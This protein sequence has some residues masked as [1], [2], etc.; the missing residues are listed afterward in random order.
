MRGERHWGFWRAVTWLLATAPVL[1]GGL[2]LALSL[3]L[4]AWRTGEPAVMPLTLAPGHTGLDR[5]TRVWI[6]TDAACELGTTKDPD[7]CFALLLLAQ[8]SDVKI[9]GVSTIFGNAP[10]AITD[11]TTRALVSQLHTD[12]MR[13]P[14]CA[15]ARQSRWWMA[16]QNRSP[17]PM[18]CC[19]GCSKK[20]RS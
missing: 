18:T 20:D 10:L 6:D 7:D 16:R 5:P 4:E 3:P 19:G 8:S 1:A 15:V 2:S 17:P 13:P 11:P 12:G 14:R 9:V